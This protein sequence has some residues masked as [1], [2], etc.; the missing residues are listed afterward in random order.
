MISFFSK[1]LKPNTDICFIT[2]LIQKDQKKVPKSQF[3]S[4]IYA[5]ARQTAVYRPFK[6]GLFAKYYRNVQCHDSMDNRVH[7]LEKVTFSK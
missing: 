1:C 7:R 2:I 4:R 6:N 3:P 5:Q